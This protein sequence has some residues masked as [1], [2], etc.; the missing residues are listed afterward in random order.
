MWKPKKGGDMRFKNN[1]D[2]TITDTETGLIW[3]DQNAPKEMNWHEAIE[4]AKSLDLAGHTDWRIPTINE[5]FSLIDFSKHN[6]ATELPNMES[7]YYWSSSTDAS[8]TANAW[9]VHFTNGSVYR[10]YKSNSNYVRC[11]RSGQ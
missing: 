2:G 3:Q 5:L 11:V 7:S 10:Y 8:S 4:Y 6:P 9:H 1:S